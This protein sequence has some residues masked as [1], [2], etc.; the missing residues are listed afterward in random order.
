MC[1]ISS[2][3]TISNT[4]KKILQFSCCNKLKMGRVCLKKHRLLVRLRF[5]FQSHTQV[6]RWL[7]VNVK[8]GKCTNCIS[9]FFTFFPQLLPTGRGWNV[10]VRQKPTAGSHIMV[11][12]F[13]SCLFF[14]L[15]KSLKYARPIKYTHEHNTRRYYSF[16]Y[17]Q[18][19]TTR[20][21]LL[22]LKHYGSF[23]VRSNHVYS[24][25]A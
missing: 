5:V 15:F 4:R 7:R 10:Q 24:M 3:D 1:V 8:T 22:L 2:E 6:L 17:K 14:L 18:I 23:N 21:M 11:M 19:H 13:S 25:Y 20:F 9:T 12:T 16:I